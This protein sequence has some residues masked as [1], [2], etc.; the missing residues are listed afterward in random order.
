MSMAQLKARVLYT[1]HAGSNA[2]S[3]LAALCAVYK[4][5]LE[6]HAK[7]EAACP[8][9]PDDAKVRSENDSRVTEKA[10]YFHAQE[11]GAG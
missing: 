6:S 4:L 2:A 11:G 8:G 3:E 7:K 1:P 10:T 9:D 5:A